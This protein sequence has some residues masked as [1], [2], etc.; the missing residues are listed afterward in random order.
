MSQGTQ[1]M[2]MDFKPKNN[3]QGYYNQNVEMNSSLYRA[4]R[5]QFAPANFIGRKTLR[6]PDTYPTRTYAPTGGLYNFTGPI[7]PTRPVQAKFQ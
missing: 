4:K 1:D 7:T 6:T 5:P 3:L 2:K